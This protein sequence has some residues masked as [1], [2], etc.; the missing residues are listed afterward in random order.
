MHFCRNR[1]KI[2]FT[3]KSVSLPP[4]SNSRPLAFLVSWNCCDK[5]VINNHLRFAIELFSILQISNCLTKFTSSDKNRV[6]CKKCHC[7]NF[8]MELFVFIVEQENVTKPWNNWVSAKIILGHIVHDE[9]MFSEEKPED[10]TC[11]ELSWERSL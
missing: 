11:W 5:Y 6:A 4:S 1:F 3:I 9:I 7:Y 8:I 2:F 10:T